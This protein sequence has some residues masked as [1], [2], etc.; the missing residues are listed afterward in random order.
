MSYVFICPGCG[1][2][3]TY[4]PEDVSEG[5]LVLCDACETEMYRSYE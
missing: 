5:E 1:N 4:G 2:V 3:E